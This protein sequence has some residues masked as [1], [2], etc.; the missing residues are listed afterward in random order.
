MEINELHLQ[1]KIIHGKPA[2]LVHICFT[3]QTHCGRAF[4]W[5]YHILEINRVGNHSSI[6]KLFETL[7]NMGF[8]II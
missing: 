7:K 6:W 1:P 3:N 8:Y 5:S 4:L 2:K